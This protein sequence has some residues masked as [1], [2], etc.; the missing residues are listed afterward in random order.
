MAAVRMWF[1]GFRLMRAGVLGLTLA[2][3]GGGGGDDG[4]QIPPPGD[5]DLTASNRDSV[6]IAAS[7]AVQGGFVINSAGLTG[8]GSAGTAAVGKLLQ[9]A[10]RKAVAALPDGRKRAAGLIDVSLL[11]DCASGTVS[12]TLDDRDNSLNATVGDVLS[13][14]FAN[15]RP[16][17][18]SDELL[19]GALSATYTNIVQS[20]LTV[21]A[22]VSV[23]NLRDSSQ[24]RG[25]SMTLN[26]GFTLNYVEPNASTST[27]QITVPSALSL[28]VVHPLYQDTVG[29]Q[30]G[31][32]LTLYY[33]LATPPG[34]GS[35][36]RTII[37]AVGKVSSTR[38]GGVFNVWSQ[39]P[40]LDFWDVDP[41]PRS[42]QVLL[43]GRNGNILLTVVSTST[44][45]LELDANG[46]A[47]YE[48]SQDVPWDSLL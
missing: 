21:A 22:S 46:D 18:A 37:E 33:D 27:T 6:A 12:A 36:G 17:L 11:F 31:Y 30:P 20:P 25:R 13:A 45:R 14:T 28:Q 23:T 16:D 42:G 10:S 19:N 34:A 48:S 9:S 7:V 2:A 40:G 24:Q 47:V 15:C 26:G 8:G 29:L 5:I 43:Q 4:G 41:Y 1:H 35:G 44:V 38:A 39:P 3:C 32:T